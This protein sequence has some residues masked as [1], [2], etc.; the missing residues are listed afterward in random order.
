MTRLGGKRN[1]K[2]VYKIK[3]LFF[4]CV[5]PSL[6]Y[7]FILLPISTNADFPGYKRGHRTYIGPLAGFKDV[8]ARIHLMA[9][10]GD[11]G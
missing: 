8:V 10:T 3:A 9:K 11:G 1:K 6:T 7:D 4:V 5:P 2:T